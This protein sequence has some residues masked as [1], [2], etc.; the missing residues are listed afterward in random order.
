MILGD[1]GGLRL[2]DESTAWGVRLNLTMGCPVTAHD[3]S[4]EALSTD[5]V[6]ELRAT[7]TEWLESVGADL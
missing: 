6:R 5:Q 3:E 4:S 1:I 7:L 2:S